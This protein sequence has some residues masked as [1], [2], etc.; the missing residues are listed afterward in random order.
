M[1][2]KELKPQSQMIFSFSK[3]KGK[4]WPCGKVLR[5]EYRK[6]EFESQWCLLAVQLRAGYLVSL[7]FSF[8][9]CK[10][11]IASMDGIAGCLKR[12]YV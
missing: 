6:Y 2:K 4:R 9:S 10:M 11:E 3:E 1:L 8:L 7:N 12:D 5:S